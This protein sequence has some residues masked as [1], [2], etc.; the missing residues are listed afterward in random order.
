MKPC[1]KDHNISTS[2]NGKV[3]FFNSEEQAT[4]DSKRSGESW[5]S[6]LPNTINHFSDD[7]GFYSLSTRALTWVRDQ[8][9]L[10]I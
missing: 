2:N 3:L 7:L 4:V 6:R 1:G 8:T 10:G 9:R 5:N